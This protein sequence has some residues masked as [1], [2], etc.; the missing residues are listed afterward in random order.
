MGGIN[1]EAIIPKSYTYY[2]KIA[3]VLLINFC[4]R[5]LKYILLSLIL[6]FF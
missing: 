1:N 4:Q 5:N 6:I 3:I 2:P